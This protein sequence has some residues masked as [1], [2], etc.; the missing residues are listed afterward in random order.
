MDRPW[1]AFDVGPT[2]LNHVWSEMKFHG[3]GIWISTCSRCGTEMRG[4]P[5]HKP[6]HGD[7]KFQMVLQ[8]CEAQLV[9]NIMET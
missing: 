6:T 5:N 7:L 1:T 4:S 3:D 2:G 8:D 9:R